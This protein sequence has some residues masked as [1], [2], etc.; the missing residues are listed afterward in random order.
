[1][2]AQGIML[3]ETIQTRGERQM[4]TSPICNI[5]KTMNKTETVTDKEKKAI[6][7]RGTGM[8]GKDR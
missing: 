6:G 4:P 1:M 3:S 5:K 7:S 8:W 2:D